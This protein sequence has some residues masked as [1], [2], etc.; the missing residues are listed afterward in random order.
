MGQFRREK[1]NAKMISQGAEA[2]LYEIEHNDRVYIV[3]ERFAKSYRVKELD[4]MVWF[5]L[6]KLNSDFWFSWDGNTLK[7]KW[8]RL[9]SAPSSPFPRRL[10]TSP[11]RK[12]AYSS[13]ATLKGWRLKWH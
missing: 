4:D 13:L 1:E 12:T 6:F 2:R 3:K 7:P 10:I 11:I 5:W 9:P 8:K